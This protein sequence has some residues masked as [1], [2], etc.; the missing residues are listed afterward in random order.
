MTIW[1][2][3]ARGMLG[4][5][6]RARLEAAR[7]AFITTDLEL[8][9]GEAEPVLAYARREKPTL[10][11]NAAAYTR[12]ND[13]ETHEAEA[14]RANGAGPEHLGRA[15]T[16]LGARVVHVSTDYVFDG[17]AQEPYREDAPT[18]PQG[19]YGRTKLAGEQRLFAACPRGALVVRTSWLFGE[20][21]PNFVRTMAR[22]LAEKDELRV[23]ADQRGRPTYTGDL[24]EVLLALGGVT[25]PEPC[26]P[27][28]YHFAN[29]GETTWH[30]FTLAIRNACLEAGLPV[31]AQRVTAVTTADFPRPAPRPAYSVLDTTKIERVLGML[32]RP[33]EAPLVEYLASEAGSATHGR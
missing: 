8:D 33:F 10:I 19:A 18:A 15:A 13:A 5:A 6:L 3:G 7:V 14:L 17:R 4:T 16:E 25:R 29:A 20:N 30:G 2:V 1:L 21:G 9:I 32:P 11:L 26:P 22:L 12:V 28:L 24:A 27:G 31:K 23:V